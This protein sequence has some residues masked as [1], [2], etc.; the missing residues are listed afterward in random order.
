MSVVF[1]KCISVSPKYQ[2]PVKSITIL[3]HVFQFLIMGRD[4]SPKFH[5]HV[6]TIIILSQDFSISH[7]GWIAVFQV[8]T[9]QPVNIFT[10]LLHVIQFLVMAG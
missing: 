1:F 4:H 6:N 3:L 8:F 2:G 7:N 9:S 5:S 10:I